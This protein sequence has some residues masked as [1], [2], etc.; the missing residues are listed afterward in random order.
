M[1]ARQRNELPKDLAQGRSQFQAWRACKKLDRRIPQTLW[2]LAVRLVK[3][4]G[5]SRTAMALG[6]DYYRLKKQAEKTVDQPQSIN[7]AFVELPSP[8]VVGKQG[9]FE[10]DNGAGARVRVQLLGYDAADVVALL[11]NFWSAD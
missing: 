5:L 9:V 11:R 6:L 8:V 7:P 2:A 10:L 4:H 3:T 1:A